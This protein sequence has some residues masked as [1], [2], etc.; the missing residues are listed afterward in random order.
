MG[1]DLS[2][3]AAGIGGF[4]INGQC[5][6]DYSGRSVSAAGDVNGDGLADLIVGAYGSDPAAG[7]YAGRSYVVFGQTGG[8]GVDLSA[9]AAG[10][11]GFV[12]NGQCAGDFS[13]SS[14]SS[15]GD[16]NGDGLADLIVGA[17]SSDPAAGIY[18]GRSYVVFGKTDGSAVNL[19]AVAAGGGGFVINGQCAYDASGR[20]VSSAGDVNGDGLADLIVGAPWSDPGAGYAMPGAATSSLARPVAAPLTSRRSRSA[21]AAS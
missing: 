17:D 21:I 5:A 13:G 8:S 18:A 15:A 2:S 9:V 1:I 3:I 7:S 10:I 19:S 6:G 14:V 12:I 20:S 16:V 4:V 11:G